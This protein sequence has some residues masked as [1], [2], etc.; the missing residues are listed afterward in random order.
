MKYLQCKL[1][2]WPAEASLRYSIL[3]W[4]MEHN[5]NKSW[6]RLSN[7]PIVVCLLEFQI[8]QHRDAKSW[9]IWIFQT[10]APLY[11]KKKSFYRTA[12][13]TLTPFK[14]IHGCPT[15]LSECWLFC[16]SWILKNKIKE[17]PGR[18]DDPFVCF[19]YAE[20]C[21]KRK[22]EIVWHSQVSGC[23]WG[24]DL[25]CSLAWRCCGLA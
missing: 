9:Y 24:F 11:L 16:C 10:V 13:Y 19:N 8:T 22:L 6:S 5:S 25:L 15:E 2:S 21:M 1:D 23:H 14:S 4:C 18:K 3:T 12:S 7:F 17:R 20:H